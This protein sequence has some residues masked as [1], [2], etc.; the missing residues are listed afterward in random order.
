MSALIMSSMWLTSRAA[1]FQHKHP[2]HL[3][4]SFLRQQTSPLQCALTPIPCTTKPSL[5]LVLSSPS[6]QA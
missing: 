6:R 5:C 2:P 1:R 4:T 3:L